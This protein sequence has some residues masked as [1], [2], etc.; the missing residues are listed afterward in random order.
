VAALEERDPGHPPIAAIQSF[1]VDMRA[2][3]R[4][5]PCA[6]SG[7]HGFVL[8]TFIDGTVLPFRIACLPGVPSCRAISL[9]GR[10]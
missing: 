5:R 8:F 4:G 7:S 2:V 9:D 3:C 1:A 6:L 10:V